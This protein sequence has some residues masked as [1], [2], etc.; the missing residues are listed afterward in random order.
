MAGTAQAEFHFLKVATIWLLG[1]AIVLLG[2]QELLKRHHGKAPVVYTDGKQMITELHGDLDVARLAREP[3]T[4]KATVQRR[5]EI[6]ARRR[7]NLRLQI[8]K[9]IP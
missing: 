1:G 8:E 5:N 2:V 6:V 7:E 9:I 4:L 3:E